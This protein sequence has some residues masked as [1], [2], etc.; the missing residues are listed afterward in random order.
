[1]HSRVCHW[2]RDRLR[3]KLSRCIY[4]HSSRQLSLRIHDPR[5]LIRRSRRY[6]VESIRLSSS[7]CPLRAQIALSRAGEFAR[8]GLHDKKGDNSFSSSGSCKTS[9]NRRR[10]KRA[11]IPPARYPSY[12]YIAGEFAARVITRNRIVRRFS[13]RERERERE[14]VNGGGGEGKIGGVV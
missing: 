1:M 12:T 4:L 9:S 3:F 2:S 7:A 13:A 5:N 14:R 8:V 11:G 10:N 6:R